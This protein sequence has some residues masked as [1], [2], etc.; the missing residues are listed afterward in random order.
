MSCDS[1][2][3]CHNVSFIGTLS[4]TVAASWCRNTLWD[5]LTQVKT[6]FIKSMVPLPLYNSLLLVLNIFFFFFLSNDQVKLEAK[7]INILEL[8]GTSGLWECRYNQVA[9]T[10]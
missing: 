5:T 9:A 4:R 1:T 2:L 8:S 10:S 7:H 3:K 6:V